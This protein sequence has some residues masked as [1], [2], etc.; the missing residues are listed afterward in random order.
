M[1]L[2]S[3]L[4]APRPASRT[5]RDVVTVAFEDGSTL[6]VTR[7]RDARARRIKLSVDERG[8]RLTLPARASAIAGTRFLDEHRDWLHAQMS[9][10]ARHAGPT[11]IAH[12]TP[13]L[14]LRGADVP[15]RWHVAR[16][17][18][19]DLPGGD[20]I[21]AHA[22][23]APSAAALRRALR[24]F[25]EAQARAD[26]A[27]WTAMHLAGLP[28]PPSSVRFKAMA[29]Q[30]GSLAPDA[31]MA[32]DRSLVLAPAAVFEYVVIHE[33]CHLLHADHS[34][35]FWHAVTARCPHWRHQ[36]AWL[37]TQ[38]RALKA[39]WRSLAG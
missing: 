5:T 20:V 9:E 35:R 17:C 16:T 11:L 37:Q 28:Q 38:G 24:D 10:I 36:R 32:L 30:W 12:V 21:D 14:P 8:A 13:A 33:L 2:L 34:P 23:P 31:A 29:S 7:V 3:R 19:F 27:R 15:L 1:S 6:E 18:R 26:V 4:L 39:R 25:Y 22:P